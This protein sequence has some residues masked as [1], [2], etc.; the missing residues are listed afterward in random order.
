MI[1]EQLEATLQKIFIGARS[2]RIEFVTSEHMLWGLLD[3][4]SV[5]KTLLG[6]RVDIKKL[7]DS[8][9]AFLTPAETAVPGKEEVDTQPTMSFQRIMQRAMM[10]V[11]SEGKAK[12]VTGSNVLIAIFEEKDSAAVSI[13]NEH[14][15]SRLDVVNFVNHGLIKEIKTS[16]SIDHT[17]FII[18][19][20]NSPEKINI[21]ISY[22]HNDEDY[23]KRLLVHLKPIERSGSINSWSDK[24]LQ[25]GRAHV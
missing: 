4:E 3:D 15:I 8:L 12:E 1:S 22:C 6:V 9:H 23:L 14:N 11:Q 13:L 2:R 19:E 21:F 17:P 18:K 25:I 10:H 20:N 5:K 24:K 16:S 7:R